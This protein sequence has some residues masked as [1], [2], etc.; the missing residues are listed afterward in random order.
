MQT[1]VKQNEPALQIKVDKLATD[2]IADFAD[3]SVRKNHAEEIDQATKQ[4]KDKEKQPIK[5]L[6]KTKNSI[7]NIIFH[8][9]EK[10]L[11]HLQSI[12]KDSHTA[13]KK[14][15]L[16]QDNRNQHHSL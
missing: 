6:L 12:Y 8:R 16:K 9:G 15:S 11:F 13:W 2:Y 7:H 1:S 10:K 5:D 14:K 4:R 3:F